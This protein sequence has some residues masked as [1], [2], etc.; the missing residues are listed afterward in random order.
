MKNI[1]LVLLLS[2][3]LG[4]S[5]CIKDP[6][7]VAPVDQVTNLDYP[8]TIN[9][10]ETFLASGYINFRKDGMLYGQNLLPFILGP[11]DHSV[12][13]GDIGY[14]DRNLIAKNN[15]NLYNGINTNLW[16]GL[17]LGVKN[18]NVCLNRCDF[19]EKNNPLSKAAIDDI[20][21]QAM[22]LRAWY[23]FHLECFYGEKY[24]DM[25]QPEN[26]DILGVPLFTEMPTSFEETRQ[27]RSSAYKVWSQVIL[28]LQNSITKLHGIQRSSNNSGKATE[29]AAKAL[30]GK[31]YVFTQ[32]WDKA[33]PVLE[34]VITNSGKSLMPF[35]K[36]SNAFNGNPSNEFNEESLFELNVER[37]KGTGNGISDITPTSNLTTGMGKFWGPSVLSYTGTENDGSVLTAGGY[38]NFFCH[39]K[40]LRR[41]GF[42]LP[43]Y[44][45]VDNWRFT[46][47][48]PSAII[49]RKIIDSAYVVQS[50]A[51]RT[52]KTA[53]PRLYVNT[54]QP[55]VDSVSDAYGLA[56]S[57]GRRSP[58]G[59]VPVVRNYYIGINVQDP[60]KY[61]GWAF[62]KYQT[63]DN[64][65]YAYH[66]C[67]GSNI[68]I[69][70]LADVYLLYA[71]AA[72]H[73]GDNATAL[74][75]INKVHRRAY[76]Q[77]INAVSVYDYASLSAA[78]KA[79]PSDKNLA[80][81]PLA[82]ERW[83]ELF[84]EGHWWF[85][86]CRWGNSVNS[87]NTDFGKNEADYYSVFS[88]ESQDPANPI[89]SS[90]IRW[91]S[92]SYCFPIPG[93]EWDVNTAM[94]KQ[95]NNPGY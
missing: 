23:Y 50:L 83:S 33:K 81:N 21:G 89:E 46:G 70:R 87:T 29:W 62:K 71:E 13:V 84:L 32:Q 75:Y 78:T 9:D 28:D 2:L 73:L 88:M 36:Y 53:D 94:Q 60:S 41:F 51:F 85:D 63:I 74:E 24:I 86:V 77:P 45:L 67:D 8:K 66:E 68:Y 55:W 58:N 79:A 57:N 43:P 27:P 26:T 95:R 65:I 31:A 11:S 1:F 42:T 34:D 10:L 49:P 15:I 3:A 76:N 93:G 72:M 20:R 30:L 16:E 37:V 82:Y 92:Y 90:K 12:M 38:S 54:L 22:F 44:Q 40:N 25:S 35:S 4:F 56:G 39:D 64:S 6:V 61:H 18:M 52:N 17:Y 69:L 19:F 47:G 48:N 91:S 7:N 59:M 80:N 5:G 14:S